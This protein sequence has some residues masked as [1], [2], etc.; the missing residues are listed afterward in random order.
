MQ[1]PRQWIAP[2]LD[3]RPKR[4]SA[5]FSAMNRYTLP[6]TWAKE[7]NDWATA[8]KVAGR[9]AQTIET[10][11]EHMRRFARQ[12]GA[13][14]PAPVSRNRL[15]DW[16]GAQEWARETRRSIYA[17]IRAFYTWAYETDRVQDNISDALPKVKAS[18]PAPR[19]APENIYRISLAN[20]DA[21][22][23]LILWLAGE[24]G[25]RRGK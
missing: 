22:A 9:S 7:I 18:E 11:S 15:V 19:P 8:L 6:P 12:T 13:G 21:R 16:A 23:R 5:N 10:R 2:R 14:G 24:A 4:F 25:L 1:N 20:A 17:S 3:A